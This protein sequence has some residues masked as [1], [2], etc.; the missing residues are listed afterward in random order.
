M[1]AALDLIKEISAQ[2]Q[3]DDLPWRERINKRRLE[4]D[5]LGHNAMML[6]KIHKET[7][8]NRMG[9]RALQRGSAQ[10]DPEIDGDKDGE[11]GI[12]I[13]DQ[14]HYHI[15][16]NPD[17]PAATPSEPA[18]SIPAAAVAAAPG[19]LA[20]A[21]PYVAT[22]LLTGGAVLGGVSLI[23]RPTATPTPPATPDFIDT[24]TDT[25]TNIG[26]YRGGK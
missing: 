11:M 24:N 1:S 13:G 14:T 9:L 2:D 15:M 23:N 12:N 6:D 18:A 3:A 5:L 16:G 21:V 17:A 8:I 22:A 4:M 19:L 7:E 26:I 20:K 25:I 10:A